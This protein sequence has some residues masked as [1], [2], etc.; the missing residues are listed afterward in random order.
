[1]NGYAV[2]DRTWK[3]GDRVELDL[4]VEP[5]WIEC[6]PRVSDNV[7]RLAIQ[8]GPIVYCAE[9][10]DQADR[11]VLDRVVAKGDRVLAKWHDELGGY[12]GLTTDSRY[13]QRVDGEI[14]TAK[15]EVPLKLIPYYAWAHRGQGQMA[16]WLASDPK[17]A[18][19]APAKTIVFMS[20]VSSSG[21]ER[22]GALRDQL[23]PKTSNDHS[24][25]FFHWW[26]KKGTTEW[27]EFAFDG[28][29]EISEVSVYWFE[30]E[31]IGE[32][33]LPKAWR[34]FY[35]D[36]TAWKPV[37][38]ASYPILKDAFSKLAFSK[39]NATGLRIEVDQPARFATGIHEVVIR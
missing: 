28:P 3:K 32:C 4:P 27:V 5:I 12:V 13:A 8:R 39:V 2:L 11:T 25:P 37:E 7:G 33:R 20:K 35:R 18:W 6:D 9:F 10:A 23:E 14:K 26:P 22:I 19:P 34:A 29:Q 24:V 16:V 36:G 17:V 1:V 21:G 30:D 15:E 31:G 38:A